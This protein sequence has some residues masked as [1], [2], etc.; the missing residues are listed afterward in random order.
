MLVSNGL[1]L[2]V[3]LGWNILFW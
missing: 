2:S 3:W 1:Y